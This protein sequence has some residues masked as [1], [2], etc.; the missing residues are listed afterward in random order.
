MKNE[1]LH[2]LF[3]IPLFLHECDYCNSCNKIQI[4][5]SIEKEL[6]LQEGDKNF[7]IES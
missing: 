1:I 4:P 7:V 5:C 3:I 6:V 2:D